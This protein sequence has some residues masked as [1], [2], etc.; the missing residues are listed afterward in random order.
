MNIVVLD[1]DG[2]INHD[3]ADYIKSPEEWLPIDG[4]IEAIA[5]LSNAGFKIYVA[6]NQSGL[7][8]GLFSKAQLD[9]MHEKMHT[10]VKAAGGTIEQVF[11]CP[12]HPDENCA[13][14][15]PATGLLDQ[16]E[17]YLG[18]K[19]DGA[20]LVGDS[21]K[22]LLLGIAKQCKPLLVL[23]GNGLKTRGTVTAAGHTGV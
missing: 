22:D 20:W 13:C 17:D 2:V 15:K 23:T 18:H 10:L 14:R 12:H 1:R 21:M 5:A 7:A 9:G 16:L 19:V 11:Y 6:T 4:S 3:S 8:R